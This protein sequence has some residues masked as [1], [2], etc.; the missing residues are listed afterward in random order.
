MDQ[1]INYLSQN[2]HRNFQKKFWPFFGEICSIKFQ[3]NSKGISF[4]VMPKK[5]QINFQKNKIFQIYYLRRF[6][7]NIWALWTNK[8]CSIATAHWARRCPGRRC[9]S[10]PSPSWGPPLAGTKRQKTQKIQRKQRQNMLKREN[11]KEVRI[12]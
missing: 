8:F 2:F 10:W 12:R 1:I 6:L 7:R 5:I 9:A 4:S 3:R 11:Y